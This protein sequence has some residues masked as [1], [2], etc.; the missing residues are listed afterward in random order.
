MRALIRHMCCHVCQDALTV[1]NSCGGVC[2]VTI[3][4]QNGSL[5]PH[6]C[7]AGLN[8]M[9]LRVVVL[10]AFA[11]PTYIIRHSLDNYMRI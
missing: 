2:G 4:I 10:E 9:M 11:P 3:R 7:S 1:C 5:C 8:N 6:A